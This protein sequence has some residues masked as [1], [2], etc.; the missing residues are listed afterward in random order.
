MLVVGG[1]QRGSNPGAVNPSRRGSRSSAVTTHNPT[2]VRVRLRRERGGWGE[3]GAWGDERERGMRR[4]MS[5]RTQLVGGDA[6]RRRR[7]CPG[8]GG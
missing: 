4:L 8:G 1:R 6:A 3:I 2:V 7:L 5:A